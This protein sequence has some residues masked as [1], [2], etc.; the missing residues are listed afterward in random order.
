MFRAAAADALDIAGCPFASG[1]GVSTDLCL[2][3]SQKRFEDAPLNLVEHP[4][5]GTLVHHIWDLPLQSSIVFGEFVGGGRESGE[6]SLFGRRSCGK[7]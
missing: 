2:V 1:G 6:G 5:Q 4:A 7:M 3:I